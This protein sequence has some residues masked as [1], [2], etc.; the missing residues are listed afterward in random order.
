LDPNPAPEGFGTLHSNF[1]ERPIVGRHRDVEHRLPSKEIGAI[2]Y[3][4]FL[5]HGGEA[6]PGGKHLAEQ[7]RGRSTRASEF[8]VRNDAI[9]APALSPSPPVSTEFVR[10]RGG[11]RNGAERQRTKLL[12]AAFRAVAAAL[13]VA[14]PK[15][16]LRGL[17]LD[18]ADERDPV[19]AARQFHR[20]LSQLAVETTCVVVWRGVLFPSG[21][22]PV[23]GMVPAGRRVNMAQKH[24]SRH[25]LSTVHS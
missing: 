4:P 1:A 14:H 18:S 17:E 9:R 15:T 16:L 24:V 2:G 12:R 23:T 13:A 10:G 22:L 19:C 5:E 6:A 7:P 21:F 11:G 20:G 3:E 8:G 25:T